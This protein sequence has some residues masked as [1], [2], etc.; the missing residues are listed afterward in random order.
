MAKC[1][2]LPATLK[3]RVTLQSVSRVSDGQGGFTETWKD[4]QSVFASI[5]PVK[6][7]ER[8]QAMQ[9]ATP[10]SHKIIMRYNAVVTTASRLKYEGRIFAV[11]EVINQDEQNRFL[12]IKAIEQG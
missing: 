1:S 8:F 12:V 4:G 11:K 3:K 9:T 10:I 7:Y 2:Y 5:E 6:A